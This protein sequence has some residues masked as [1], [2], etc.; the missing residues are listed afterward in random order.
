[1]RVDDVMSAPMTSSETKKLRNECRQQ[2]IEYVFRDIASPTPSLFSIPLSLLGSRG[3]KRA[4]R[5]VAR[6]FLM[7]ATVNIKIDEGPRT[8]FFTVRTKRRSILEGSSTFFLL[9]FQLNP[10]VVFLC[11]TFREEIVPLK[12]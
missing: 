3:W 2:Q 1:M 11:P 9:L 6:R 12:S 10:R 5:Q 7:M 8:S 4:L